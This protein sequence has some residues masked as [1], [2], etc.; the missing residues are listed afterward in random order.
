MPI[1]R[2]EENNYTYHEQYQLS[3]SHPKEIPH[4]S[5]PQST[6]QNHTDQQKEVNHLHGTS[7]IS[8]GSSYGTDGRVPQNAGDEVTVADKDRVASP[9]RYFGSFRSVYEQEVSYSNSSTPGKEDVLIQGRNSQLTPSLNASSSLQDGFVAP[10]SA[11]PVRNPSLEQFHFNHGVQTAKSIV[12]PSNRPLDSNYSHSESVGPVGT[13]AHDATIT[14]APHAWTPTGTAGFFPQAPLPPSGTQMDLS[15]VSQPSLPIHPAP[16]F[17]RIPAPSYRPGVPPV[18]FGVGAGTSLHPASAFP[19]D[20][21]G[22][23]NLPERPK[24]SAVPNWL[25]EE[26]LKNKS[27]LA[28]AAPN[29]QD[30]NS[31]HSVGSEDAEKP[32]K[33]ADQVDSKSIDSNKSTEDEEDDEDEVEAARTAAINQ[34]IKRVLTEVLMKVTDDLFDEIA[35][36]VL[37]EDDLTVE[38]HEPTEPADLVDSKV[39]HSAISTPKASAKIL[40]PVKTADNKDSGRNGDSAQSSPRGDVLGLANYDSDEDDGNDIR[41]QPSNLITLE[42]TANSSHQQANN[43]QSSQYVLEGMDKQDVVIKNEEPNGGSHNAKIGKDKSDQPSRSSSVRENDKNSLMQNV[44]TSCDDLS[45][46]EKSLK[47]KYSNEALDAVGRKDTIACEL[48]GGDAKNGKS[49]SGEVHAGESKSISRRTEQVSNKEDSVKEGKD[50]IV[51]TGYEVPRGTNPSNC[52]D[53]TKVKERI[54]KKESSKEKPK[55]RSTRVDVRES[56]GRSNSKHQDTKVDRKDA[57]KDKREKSKDGT[58]RKREQARE[59]KEDRSRRVTKD[60]ARNSSKRSPS[61]RAKDKIT[62]EK[63]QMEVYQLWSLL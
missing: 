38:V 13:V 29:H 30:G 10:P 41:S 19:G 39:P 9:Q 17:G 58:D 59:E 54:Y 49:T 61:P 56:D 60:S 46:H 6:N 34:E 16:P 23:F 33:K 26:I 47:R 31:F 3:A 53:S 57:T 44:S 45:T 35:T 40:I 43:G 24:K 4:P 1:G 12:D 36:K 22:S 27:V 62:L 7:F 21:N 52:N 42:R 2:V 32:F 14:T 28:G 50:S 48:T 15:V 25:R 8:S 55:D 18:P 51:K 11:I 63:R 20:I 5:L 37:N